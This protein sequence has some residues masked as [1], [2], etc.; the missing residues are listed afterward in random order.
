[1]AYV[2]RRCSSGLFMTCTTQTVVILGNAWNPIMPVKSIAMFS[3]IL[4]VVN[5][6]FVLMCIPPALVFYDKIETCCRQE[7]EEV[8]K[9]MHADLHSLNDQ[10]QGID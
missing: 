9:K 2:L 4:V 3:G 1:M 7:D 6:F 5:F 8:A 10:Y